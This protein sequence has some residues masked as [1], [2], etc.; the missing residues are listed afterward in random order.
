MQ[1]KQW[2]KQFLFR[3]NLKST[4]RI[5]FSKIAVKLFVK[6]FKYN[7]RISDYMIVAY[8]IHIAML[9]LPRFVFSAKGS[10]FF[11]S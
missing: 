10:K 1:S 4:I 11:G 3:L 2:D 6:Y 8:I 5:V 9:I 7:K